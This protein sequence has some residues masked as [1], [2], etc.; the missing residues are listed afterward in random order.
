MKIK[1]H[2]PYYIPCRVL[3]DGNEWGQLIGF[4]KHENCEQYL[5]NV[6]VDGTENGLHS[7][8]PYNDD[9]SEY[10]RIKPILR[11]LEDLTDEDA[12][13]VG[14][15]NAYSFLVDNN[16]YVNCVGPFLPRSFH[17]LVSQGY[18]VFGLIPAGLAIDAKT[19]NTPDNDPGAI[20]PR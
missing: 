3:V 20:H 10:C 15:D 16:S 7:G 13:E 4:D 19:L 9:F 1:G 18:D 6:V 14:Y 2:I 12:Q 8:M 5:W 17:Y 11:K